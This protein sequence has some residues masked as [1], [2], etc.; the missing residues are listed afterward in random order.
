MDKFVYR[1]RMRRQERAKFQ[2]KKKIIRAF[3][4]LCSFLFVCGAIYCYNILTSY[5]YNS[6]TQHEAYE[7]ITPSET[8]KN[9]AKISIVGNITCNDTLIK[10]AFNTETNS[11]DFSYIFKNISKYLIDSDLT[12]GNLETNFIGNSYRIYW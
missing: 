3:I 5:V 9:I 8:T 10:E 4:F 7:N 2:K 6:N 12:I 11:Y 1:A